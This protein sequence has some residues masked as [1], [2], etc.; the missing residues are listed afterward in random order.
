ME[1]VC[2]KHTAINKIVARCVCIHMSHDFIHEHVVCLGAMNFAPHYLPCMYMCVWKSKSTLCLVTLV[3][4]RKKT[5][6]AN[7]YVTGF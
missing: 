4:R 6:I 1:H 5:Q 3:P 2:K 7:S